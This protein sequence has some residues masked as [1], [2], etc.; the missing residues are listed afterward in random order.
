MLQA[1]TARRLVAPVRRRGVELHILM[2]VS[3]NE[4]LALVR[5]VGYRGDLFFE[6][7]GATGPQ[8]HNLEVDPYDFV[9]QAE[10][11]LLDVG[12]AARVNALSN[13]KRAIDSTVEQAL[14]TFG[15][16]GGRESRVV[17]LNYLASLG[18]V[19]PR[20][21]RRV[22]DARNDAEH[23]FRQPT[24]EQAE[25]AV[26]IATLFVASVKASLAMIPTFR[27]WTTPM[28]DAGY[29]DFEWAWTIGGI[30]ILARDH[31]GAFV[32]ETRVVWG[33][34]FFAPIIKVGYASE[35]DFRLEEAGD[36]LVGLISEKLADLD[37]VHAEN[38]S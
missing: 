9:L 25:E 37:D 30:R 16:P 15:W 32:G 14:R 5:G 18:L 33:D 4:L 34:P 35:R 28:A 31:A 17:R 26:D 20:I 13:A 6:P 21:I 3:A 12:P 23:E 11:D 2:H 8:L 1:E 7:E 38:G 22:I 36:A 19:A 24:T 29:L 27:A 10:H